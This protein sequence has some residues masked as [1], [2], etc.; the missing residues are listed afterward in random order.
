[1]RYNGITRWLCT[2]GLVM[3]AGAA[4][5]AT[6]VVTSTAD[7]V[8]DDGTCTL[9]EAIAASVEDFPSGRLAGECAQGDAGL[10]RINFALTGPGPFVFSPR[11]PLPVVTQPTFIDGYSQRGSKPNSLA[12]GND[13]VIL[14][15]IDGSGTSATCP[16]YL[17]G[18]RAQDVSPVQGMGLQ[19]SEAAATGSRLRGIA[20][21]GFSSS[22]AG[23]IMLYQV[24]GVQIDG[25]FIGLHPDGSRNTNGGS[26]IVILNGDYIEVTSDKTFTVNTAGNLIGGRSPAERN[27]IS[28]NQDGVFIG[29]KNNRIEGNYIGVNP[30][31]DKS[32][33][34]S[35]HGVSMG[36][37]GV[38]GFCPKAGFG[39]QFRS[40]ANSV[41]GLATGQGN[42][43]SAD[44][45]AGDCAVSTGWSDL[46]HVSGNAI[47]TSAP[48]APFVADGLGVKLGCGVRVGGVIMNGVAGTAARNLVDRNRI[49]NV[50]NGILVTGNSRNNDLFA[51]TITRTAGPGIDLGDDGV[52]A[53]D[54]DDA[55][56]GA[57]GAQNFPVALVGVGGGG[58]KGRVSSK[59]NTTYR[60]DFYSNSRCLPQTS[61][62]AE[63]YLGSTS[64]VT[65]P[66]GEA[67]FS[68]SVPKLKVEQF[69]TATAT[70]IGLG[71]GTS[72][73]SEC[74]V[75]G[76]GLAATVQI[77]SSRNP[78]RSHEPYTLTVRVRGVPGMTPTG[79]V[80]MRDL[81]RPLM[82]AN[83]MSYPSLAY[84]VLTPS[85]SLLDTAEA[86]FSSP[87]LNWSQTTI[88]A[89]PWGN[90]SLRA[91]YGGDV[92]FEP[93]TSMDFVQRTYRE[94][95]DL[96]GN[97]LTDLV[98]CDGMNNKLVVGALPGGTFAGVMGL[99]QLHAGRTVLGLG[100][101]GLFSQPAV[102][103]RDAMGQVG[104]TI[105]AG[106]QPTGDF[107]VPLPA[108][109]TVAAFGSLYGDLKDG[110]VTYDA[111]GQTYGILTNDIQGGQL[112]L[113]P[114]A[115]LSTPN[116]AR[117]RH[118]GDFDGDGN[119]DLLLADSLDG[120]LV[121]LLEGALNVK[122]KSGLGYMPAGGTVVAVAD[123]NGDGRSDVVWRLATG[124]YEI[125]LHAGLA[126]LGRMTPALGPGRAIV[127]TA[128]FDNGQGSANG[129]SSLVVRDTATGQLEAAINTGLD[130]NGLP[131]FAAP[132]VIPTGGRTDLTVCVP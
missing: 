59:P 65:D 132:F 101:V 37:I 86:V 102:F 91:D 85:A 112:Q 113:Y 123:F 104:G 31:G 49:A 13:A 60:V 54:A 80:I 30:Q 69:I 43:F 62:E 44:S 118:T 114:P 27:V 81:N 95:S 9:R 117:V 100:E 103:W 77:L 40:E 2:I 111:N 68:V 98:L 11:A 110:L 51:N 53:N 48:G 76:G 121:W 32:I 108:G 129:R 52:T 90:L 18:Q 16:T 109:H 71:D 75:V 63:R 73:L 4:S 107:G 74:V 17:R 130:A 64:L 79:V 120:G 29:G 19:F 50:R 105:F 34:N 24:G 41:G 70:D 47:G 56:S 122:L 106:G 5:G 14:I 126:P 131:V 99:P 26:G 119:V 87:S 39:Y 66:A 83:G 38:G 78:A 45:D 8:A 35:G 116:P 93:A 33:A 20:I 94:K 3:A 67:A 1:M 6:I 84:S 88:T 92:D 15:E 125:A 42:F 96:D 28:A 25:N 22:H 128:H 115:P 36:T 23:A 58:I 57:N 10:D 127:G 12:T 72:E 82:F 124:V 46:N 97:G 55:D 89:P 61:G 21:G 7:S